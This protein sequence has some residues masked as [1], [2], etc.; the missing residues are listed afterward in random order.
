MH[1]AQLCASYRITSQLD[2]LIDRGPFSNRGLLPSEYLFHAR[3]E[4]ARLANANAV[5]LLW[6]MQLFRTHGPRD[7]EGQRTFRRLSRPYSSPVCSEAELVT[8]FCSVEYVF[9]PAFLR[10]WATSLFPTCRGAS[11]GMPQALCHALSDAW[12]GNQLSGLGRRA[13]EE[14]GPSSQYLRRSRSRPSRSG[15]QY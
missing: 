9:A 3:H 8:D 10:A 2:S 6:A 13:S 14:R 7:W 4:L 15:L 5:D 12:Q 1:I 11:V